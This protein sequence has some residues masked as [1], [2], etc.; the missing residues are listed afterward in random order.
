MSN[1]EVLNV[2]VREKS[3]STSSKHLRA[4]GQIPAI[5]YGHGIAPVSLAVK[6]SEVESMIRHG[7]RVVNLTGGIS[8][9]A[10]VKEVQW[11]A[12]GNEVLHLDLTRV[13]KD[14]LIETTVEVE[15]RGDAPG[16]KVGGVLQHLLHEVEIKCP[17]HSIPEKLEANVNSLEMGG[18]IT[19][20]ELIVPEGASLVG[21][22]NAVVVQCVEATEE[23]E[24]VAAVDGAEPEV[25]GRKA[26]EGDEE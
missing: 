10:F 24:E 9:N 19:L 13:S 17:A 2:E 11:D 14:E 26:D 20:S 18:T 15:L 4:G 21:D 7:S 22:A 23:S 5:L 8:E 6:S 16:T 12:F 1:T 25:I 3:G